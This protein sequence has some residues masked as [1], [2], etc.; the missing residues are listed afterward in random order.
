MRIVFV[1]KLVSSL[2]SKALSMPGFYQ[3]LTD[4]SDSLLKKHT[5]APSSLTP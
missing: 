4:F 5:A 2:K 3:W 1:D